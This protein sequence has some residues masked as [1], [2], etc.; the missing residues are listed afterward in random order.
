M[1]KSI[2][3]KKNRKPVVFPIVIR[4]CRVLTGLF[5]TCL[6]WLETLVDIMPVFAFYMAGSVGI[7]GSTDFITAISMWFLPTLFLGIGLTAF[8]MFITKKFWVWLSEKEKAIIQKY[9]KKA[10]AGKD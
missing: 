2:R 1:K 10:E 8:L 9:V 6:I 5:V 4:I 3:E 7:T